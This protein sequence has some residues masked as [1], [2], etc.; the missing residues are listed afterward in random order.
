M[1]NLLWV[2]VSV[3]PPVGEFPVTATQMEK[4]GLKNVCKKK[5][6]HKNIVLKKSTLYISVLKIYK[7]I[8]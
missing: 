5:G 3:I 7:Y 2:R 6:R 4:V 1:R 8:V